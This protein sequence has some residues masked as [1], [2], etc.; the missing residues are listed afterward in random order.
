MILKALASGKF[1]WVVAWA[2]ADAS[3][4]LLAAQ[5]FVQVFQ[6]AAS[7][8]SFAASAGTFTVAVIALWRLRHVEKKVDGMNTELKADAVAKQ[9]E[10]SESEKTSAFRAGQIDATKNPILLEE[11]HP[12]PPDSPPLDLPP[13]AVPKGPSP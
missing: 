4:T 2:I 8:M 1:L 7:I 3:G 12:A 11:S 6:G 5:G 13:T 10:L 9:A